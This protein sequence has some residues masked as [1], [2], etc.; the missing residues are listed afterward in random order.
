MLREA[1]SER[2]RET[3]VCARYLVPDT[4]CFVDELKS[5][6][7]LVECGHFIVAVPLVGEWR[8]VGVGGVLVT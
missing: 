6:R 1:A 3:T 4:N 5:I 2:G 8:G 7:L